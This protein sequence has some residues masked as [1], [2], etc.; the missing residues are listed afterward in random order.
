MRKGD[1]GAQRQR[2]EVTARVA[3]G[4]RRTSLRWRPEMSQQ[5]KSPKGAVQSR[6]GYSKL[7]ERLRR[8][9]AAQRHLLPMR[10]RLPHRQP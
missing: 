6:A 1:P 7:I 2:A 4:G 10:A 9:P 3:G 5:L 8:Q